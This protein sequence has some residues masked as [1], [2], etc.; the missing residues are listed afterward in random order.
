[1]NKKYISTFC[2]ITCYITFPCNTLVI[3]VAFN[4]GL[5]LTSVYRSSLVD[6]TET[7]CNYNW[8]V[9]TRSPTE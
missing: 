8:Q 5:L 1:M 4:T 2:Y 6:S 3:Y 9:S 7:F